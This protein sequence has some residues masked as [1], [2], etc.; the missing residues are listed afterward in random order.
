MS[1]RADRS[2]PRIRAVNKTKRSPPV[3]YPATPTSPPRDYERQHLRTVMVP[4]ICGQIKTR[5]TSCHQLCSFTYRQKKQT[6]YLC[7]LAAPSSLPP[8][9]GCDDSLHKN[10]NLLWTT[11]SSKC[12]E[13]VMCT[14]PPGGC[15][16]NYT[17][18][19]RRPQSFADRSSRGKLFVTSGLF[20]NHSQ[21]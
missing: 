4:V 9:S 18:S 12:A 1:I 21:V 10:K 17:P 19:G 13:N 11:E 15:Y 16:E 14:A 20:L 5:S 3:M 7:R 2:G 6:F 8:T